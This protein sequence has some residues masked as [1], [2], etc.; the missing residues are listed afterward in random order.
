[1]ER[2]SLRNAGLGGYTVIEL[3][4]AVALLGILLGMT[5]VGM[6]T[7]VSKEG[8]R[9]LAYALASEMRSARA[10]AQKSGRYVAVC[11]PSD[12]K[13]VPFSRSAV[14]R[15][16]DQRGDVWRTLNFDSEFQA[17]IFAGRWSDEPVA[18]DSALPSAWDT[19]TRDEIAIF[20]RPDGTAFSNDLRTREGGLPIVVAS[21]FIGGSGSGAES[22][23][24]GASNPQTIWVSTSGTVR[25]EPN[26]VP[27]GVLP[28]GESDVRVARLNLRNASESSPE[29][30]SAVL[31]PKPVDTEEGTGVAQS[32][33]QIHPFQKDN[34]QLEY[35]LVTI[36][37]EATDSDGGPLTYVLSADVTR[38]GE[39]D[40]GA[41]SVPDLKGKMRFVYDPKARQHRWKA[42][43]SWRPPPGAPVKTQYN[44]TLRVTDPEGNEAIASTETELLPK[45]VS[46]P[47]ARVAMATAEGRIYLTNLDGGNHAQIT[48]D[49]SEKLPFF[50]RDGSRI[51]SFHPVSGS[52]HEL[53]SRAANSSSD[54]VPLANFEGNPEDVWMDPTS[55]YAVLLGG[56][57]VELYPWGYAHLVS[58][59]GGGS[60]G[61][62]GSPRYE[63]RQ[64]DGSQRPQTLQTLLIVNLMTGRQIEVAD[65]AVVGS[66]EWA[67]NQHGFFTYQQI[68]ANPA[69]PL[70]VLPGSYPR[71]P[72]FDEDY[73]R[74]TKFL[75][76]DPFTAVNSSLRVQ[77]AKN[78]RYNPANPDWYA[79]VDGT[80]LVVRSHSTSVSLTVASGTFEANPYGERNPSWSANGQHLAYVHTA[81]G[82]TMVKASRIFNDT[83]TALATPEQ[84]YASEQSGASLAQ[85]DPEGEWIYYLRNA[86]VFRASVLNPRRDPVEISKEIKIPRTD[87]KA[88]IESYVISP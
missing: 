41:F 20:F 68:L 24:T 64:S 43:V 59:G 45:I 65:N 81:G 21:G 1:M 53:R 54:F 18:S 17:T 82:A 83:G 72:G 38:G 26:T 61:D 35:G 79:T 86:H 34:E 13:T 10:E 19:S 52:T 70:R 47:P 50:S 84:T 9:G 48:R 77:S 5:T 28:V 12:G 30:R 25:V 71:P 58:T 14:L 6:R 33:V 32:F 46:L 11:F 51:F 22:T 56:T 23:L 8:P 62:G 55:C 57:R 66:F 4:L 78:R 67:A 87:T 37:V 60:D 85:L 76:W 63:L 16:G 15:R 39:T 80:D 27:N 74:A 40:S 42:T 49:G 44:L 88:S 69:V 73:P 7:T 3:I 36:E 75:A 29:I 31:H 2:R